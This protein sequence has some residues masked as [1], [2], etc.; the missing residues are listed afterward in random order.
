MLRSVHIPDRSSSLH[1]GRL[2]STIKH[3][4]TVDL[5]GS[6][7]RSVDVVRV[8][9]QVAVLVLVTPALILVVI[10]GS[11][12]ALSSQVVR[13]GKSITNALRRSLFPR[14]HTIPFASLESVSAKKTTALP[15]PPS[16]F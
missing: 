5:V 6:A 3:N 11:A 4:S 15:G 9:V 7:P 2:V 1:E 13:V 14:I 10:L 16:P 8:A 12:L